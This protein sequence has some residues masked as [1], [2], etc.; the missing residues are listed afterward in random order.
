MNPCFHLETNPAGPAG[1]RSRQGLVIWPLLRTLLL[2]GAVLLTI[3]AA[4]Y[5][6]ENW[7]GKRA[8]NH[9]RRA[10]EASGEKWEIAALAPPAVP[11]GQNLALS[12]LLKPIFD[13][14]R[15]ANGVQWHNSNG[16]ERLRQIDLNRAASSHVTRPSLGSLE[17]GSLTDLEAFRLFL[18]GS[19]NFPQAATNAPAAQAVLVAL[20]KFDAE[21]RELKIAAAE[22]PLCRFP[23]DYLDEPPPAVL[24]PHFAIVK[25]LA[26]VCGLRATARLHLGQTGEALADTE[27]VFRLSDAIRDEPLL[28]GHLVRV[29]TLQ[30]GLQ[31]MR[32]GLVLRAW[33]APQLAQ[34]EQ[35]LGALN[36]LAEH[37][38]AMRGERAFGVGTMEYIRRQG[39]RADPATLF[40]ESGN[41]LAPVGLRLMPSG[42]WRQNMVRNS[43]MLQDYTLAAVDPQARRV[44]PEASRAGEQ[45]VESMASGPYTHFAKVLLPALSKATARSARAQS[46]VDCTRV[47]CAL[48]RYRLAQGR[49]PE[50]LSALAPHY[51][52]SIPLDVVDGQ[53]LRYRLAAPDQPLLYSVGWNQ[54]D[55]GGQRAWTNKERT[56]VKAEEG[57]WVWGPPENPSRRPPSP[58]TWRSYNSLRGWL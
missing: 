44:N 40:D 24:L 3:V 48:E 50:T 11:D 22:R 38:H 34:L 8:W 53:P 10:L 56:S 21:L 17:K 49:F 30:L 54:T 32:E 1:R 36:L 33:N 46:F 23:V 18:L 25:N 37:Q 13:Y 35:R 28:I 55:D 41:I 29:A 20:G 5:V 39:W 26:R 51:L 12:A 14:T 4:F 2:T 9:H 45:A 27:L 42:W 15:G 7:R 31:I 43:Q 52:Q 47:A 6:V 16:M 58:P 19:T 57:D